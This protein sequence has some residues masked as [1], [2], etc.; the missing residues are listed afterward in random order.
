[1]FN[2]GIRSFAIFIFFQI[3][4]SQLFSSEFS[5]ST[6]KYFLSSISIGYFEHSHDGDKD[7]EVVLQIPMMGY[8]KFY[9]DIFSKFNNGENLGLVFPIILS[10]DIL[11]QPLIF[12]S[13]RDGD[14]GLG[15]AGTIELR[16]F[17]HRR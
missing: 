5:E 12:H 7:G 3:F 10:R 13:F 1:M 8:K 15:I 14:I 9:V 17:W 2:T 11:I 4:S 6:R 16:K